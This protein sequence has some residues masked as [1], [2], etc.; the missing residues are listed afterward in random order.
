MLDDKNIEN[1]PIGLFGDFYSH[2][3]SFLL[4][5]NNDYKNLTNILNRCNLRVKRVFSKSFIEG[6]DI[7]NENLNIE[8][9]LRFKLMKMTHKYYFSKIPL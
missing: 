2:E 7:I 6:A 4:I 8:S 3:L 9:F 5:N 1:L